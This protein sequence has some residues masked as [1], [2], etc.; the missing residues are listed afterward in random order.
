MAG[1]Q[2]FSGTKHLLR[3]P[4]RRGRAHRLFE[5]AIRLQGE[6]AIEEGVA[7]PETVA[8]DQ[9]LLPARGPLWHKKDRQANRVPQGLRGVDRDRTWGYSSHHGWVQGYIYE[10]VVT[11]REN[12]T[13]FPLLASAHTA[14]VSEHVTFG[15]KIK[16]L[17]GQTVDETQ[18]QTHA[19][20]HGY[21]G[22]A[23]AYASGVV[24]K[25]ERQPALRAPRPEG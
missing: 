10:V 12:S 2:A 16:S 13:V 22:P 8:V 5:V 4:T 20:A 23:P 17:P 9:S 24:R 1:A 25:Q 21:N 3:P 11:A 14:C 19:H 15:P 18:T 7:D 6:K